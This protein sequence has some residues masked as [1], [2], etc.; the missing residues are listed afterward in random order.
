MVCAL[1][2]NHTRRIRR[3]V[4]IQSTPTLAASAAHPAPRGGVDVG[5]P[6]CTRNHTD[7]A[8]SFALRLPM[9]HRWNCQT[10]THSASWD[11][12]TIE[13]RWLVYLAAIERLVIMPA[14]IGVKSVDGSRISL[15]LTK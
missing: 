3:R 1:K 6:P 7:R 8:S 10:S 14:V 12:L 5:V 15:S 11:G 13:A 2:C 4:G 9:P